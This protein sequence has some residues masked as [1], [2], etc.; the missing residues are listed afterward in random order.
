MFILTTQLTG[1]GGLSHFNK[2]G[3]KVKNIH[4]GKE[5][6]KLAQFMYVESTKQGLRTTPESTKQPFKLLNLL[7]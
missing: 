7:V 4:I 5:A 3:K 2:A 6:V 1:T